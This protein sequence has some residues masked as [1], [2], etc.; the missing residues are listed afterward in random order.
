MVYARGDGDGGGRGFG[1]GSSSQG[2]QRTSDKLGSALLRTNALCA[3]A[4]GKR[5]RGGAESSLSF[6]ILCPR[7]L[8]L[9]RGSPSAGP[10][11]ERRF[12]EGGEAEGGG[13]VIPLTGVFGFVF[14][15]HVDEISG[16]SARKL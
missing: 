3:W 16:R 10:V 4:V 9:T 2:S 14:D 6:E 15:G 7:L 11:C 13:G 5:D 12:L 1:R 8:P